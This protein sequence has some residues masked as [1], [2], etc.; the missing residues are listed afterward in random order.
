MHTCTT[1]EKRAIM[2]HCT[3]ANYLKNI[4]DITFNFT[5]SFWSVNSSYPKSVMFS[6]KYLIKDKRSLN[7]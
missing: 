1:A 3:T 7:L 2:V 4:S 6:R 5:G